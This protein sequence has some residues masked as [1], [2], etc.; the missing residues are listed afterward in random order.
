MPTTGQPLISSQQ[1]APS[2]QPQAPDSGHPRGAAG[3]EGGLERRPSNAYG[4]HRQTSVIH[5]LQHSRNTSSNSAAANSPLSPNALAGSGNSHNASITSTPNG[6]ADFADFGSGF[7]SPIARAGLHAHN[8]SLNSAIRAESGTVTAPHALGHQRKTNLGSKSRRGQGNPPSSL[9][10]R[11]S[12]ARTPG[13]YALHHLLNSFVALADHK[14]NQCIM[15]IGQLVTPVEHIC[16][17]GADPTFDQLISALGHIARQKPKPLIDSLMFWRKAKSEAA[18]LAK[19][20]LQP[21][22]PGASAN[23]LSVNLPRRNTEPVQKIADSSVLLVEAESPSSPPSSASSEN[24][25]FAERR[26]TVSVYLV[27]RVLIEIFEQSTLYAITPDLA[28]RLEDIVFGQLK[29][30]DP[31]QIANSS[32]RMANWRIYGQ[33]LGYMSGLDFTSV[34]YKF[35]LELDTCQKDM[36]RNAGSASA[37]EAEGRAELLVLGMRHLQIKTSPRSCWDESCDFLCTVAR[38]FVA[39]HGQRLKQAYCQVLEKLLISVASDTESELTVP[40]WRDFLEIMNTRLGPMLTK[41]RHWSSGF[42]LSILLLCVSPTDMFAAQWLSSISSMTAKLKDR[43]TRG[44]ALQSICRLTWTYLY[45]IADLSAQSTRKIEDVMKI[46]LPLGRKTH[47]STEPYVAEPLMQLIRIIGY[48][49]QEL[50]FRTIIFPLINS[51]L[52]NSG[53]DL[54]IE[55]MEPEKM[56]IGIRAFLAIM[57]DLEK[58]V[59]G[60]PPFQHTFATASVGEPL[61]TS[62]ILIKPQL[63]V[64]PRPAMSA[65]EDSLSRPVNMAAL[66]EIPKHYYLRFCE[67]LGKITI[68]CDNAFGGQAAL[69]EKLSGP[70]PRT[71]LQEAFSFGRGSDGSA[72]EQKQA[73]YDLLHVAI[74]AL[75]RCLSDHI[76]FNSLINLLCTGSAHIQPNI[77][78]SSA[79]SLK[80]I[81]RQGHAQSVAVG[82]P[83]FIFAYDSKY[84]T[85]SDE[86]MLESGHIENTLTLYVEL[87]QIWTEELKYKGRGNPLD[88]LDRTGALQN[89]GA[90]LEMTRV[91]PHVDEIEAHGLF[92]LCSQSRR[93]R[94]FAV[95]VLRMVID[96]DRAL[97]NE[98]HTRII[99]ILEDES[100]RVLDVNDDNLS[101][102][103]RSRLQKGK[104][105]SATHNTLIEICSSQVSYDST[106]WFKVFP[107]LIRITFEICPE[108]IVRSR[109]FVCERLYQLQKSIEPLADQSRTPQ[110]AAVDNRGVN[111]SAATPPEILIDQWRLYL[112]MAC[113]TLSGAGAQSQCQ[114]A[115]AVH[116]RKTSKSS[117]GSTE[118]MS[119]ARSLFSAIIPLL[120]A[121]PDT[122]R[123][124]I[125]VALGSIN[126]KLY[127]TLLESLQYAV[128]TCNNE[129]KARIGG[130]QRTPSS[131]MRNRK[132]DRLR[133]EVTHVYKLTS[134]FLRDPDVYNDDWVLNNLVIYAKDLRIFLSDAEVQNGWEFQRLRYHYCGL[135]EEVFEGINRSRNPS[136]WMPF[137]S[138]KSS[139]TLMEDWCGYSPNQGQIAHR[140]DS[141]KQYAITHQQETGERLNLNAAME[142]E[143]KNLRIAALSAMASLCAGPISIKTESKSVLQFQLPR[144]L[145]WL[146][147][148]FATPSDKVHA[149]GRRALKNLIIHNIDYPYIME[150]AIQRCYNAARPKALGSYF[151]VVTGVLIEQQGYPLEFWRILGAVL[152]TL[153]NENRDIRM[154]SAHLLRTLEERQQRSSKLQ[155]FDI[156]I[157]DKTTAVYKLA[158][159]EY[160]KRLAKAH[161]ALAFHIFSEFSLHFKSVST[162]YQRN[163]VAA[164]LPWIQTINLQV[165]PSGGPTANSYMLLSNLFEITI[166]SSNVLHN[167]VQALWQALATSPHGGNV[168]LILDFIILLSLERREQN[169]VDYAKQI[170]VYLSATPA[171]SRV[172]EFFLLQLVPKNMVNEKKSEQTPPDMKGLPYVAN[173]SEILPMGNKQVSVAAFTYTVLVLNLRRLAFLWAKYL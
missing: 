132:T 125:V 122:I 41:A 127:R 50:C 22:R 104:R 113:V 31:A 16:G 123:N 8:I 65:Q 7:S 58:G 95:K 76:P 4:H 51:D 96:F 45:R 69:N 47:L 13:E 150:H 138:R 169:F 163:M 102:A 168:Q 111:R 149:I 60:R 159:F 170:V 44:L 154:K 26:A 93:G 94:A 15:N 108:A 120:S 112:V 142:I 101:V 59:P 110:N 164:M 48:K 114:L 42:P 36:A 3:F 143:K 1:R 21:Q 130:Q 116:T 56:V 86:G 12:E 135:M 52:F 136:R 67:I 139:F 121:G 33:L 46:A 20:Q 140:E 84:S 85:M 92:F 37:K 103:E 38:L 53:K 66:S 118:K 10:R 32:L 91:N 107:N 157:S 81:A 160:S 126:H 141:M 57:S 166:G 129:A 171:G 137:E 151:E 74:Q 133:T 80:S 61:P 82:F 117:A 35:L 87:L 2:A 28:G 131:A 71:P 100:Q 106:L 134:S 172:I 119:S 155:D 156:S 98:V 18:S 23:G 25:I 144:M 24:A 68:L 79:Q 73:Y 77:A 39:A 158:Q 173:L 97:G 27:C 124:A 147:S 167:E 162:E 11:P 29:S 6:K 148:I 70:N 83:R 14:I 40:K 105:K 75:P 89:R 34:T 30:V 99:R 62:S 153:G 64:D 54:K 146:E 152:F 90:K 109:E 88:M 145:S 49:Y 63:L 78:A 165:E 161:S 55:Q 9:S 128:T 43:P 115:N 19:S 17:P 72:T 5:G